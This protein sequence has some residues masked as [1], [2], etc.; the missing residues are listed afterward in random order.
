MSTIFIITSVK[1]NTYAR[2]MAICQLRKHFFAVWI[3]RLVNGGIKNYIL[4][5]RTQGLDIYTAIHE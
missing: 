5:L 1:V 3:L 2:G 4:Q